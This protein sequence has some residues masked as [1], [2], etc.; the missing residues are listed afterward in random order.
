MTSFTALGLA[1]PIARAVA[2]ER[3]TDPTPIQAAAIPVILSGRDMIGIAQT[4]TGKTAAFAL[5]LLQQVGVTRRVAAAPKRCRVLVLTPTRELAG[6]IVDSFRTYGRHLRVSVTIAIGGVPIGKQI[7]AVQAGIDVLV[8]TPG[9][10]LDL[11]HSRSLSLDAVE[12][13]VL[14]EA[15]RMLDMGFVHEVRRIAA[16]VPKQRQT[17]LF[18]AT[19]P[20]V[21]ARLAS[22]MLTN[23]AT[24]SVAPPS[25][26]VERVQQRAVHVARGDKPALLARLLTT[27]TIDRALIFSRTKHGA[28]RVV[29]DLAK[30]GIDSEAIHGNKSQGQR[31]RTLAA[32]RSGKVRMLVATDIAARGIDV[33]GVS[34]VINYDLPNVPESYVH[35]IGRTA[36]AGNT[37]IAIS[38]CSSDEA[39]FLRAIEKLIR[40]AIPAEFEGNYRPAAAPGPRHRDE[41]AAH[42]REERAPRRQSRPQRRRP[43]QKGSGIGAVDFMRRPSRAA[44]EQTR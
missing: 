20:P 19:M 2:D 21:I 18:S 4:G 43:T 39:P 36:R 14:D 40:Q 38:F 8:A 44:A 30:A 3:Y 10:L 34:H 29:R 5:P 13:L 22:E 12:L 23:P 33:D 16:M 11:I 41:R 31:E 27:E 28:D 1:E 35:R 6:Q 26:T 25:S 7:R 24:V 37:G 32:F 9:R 15:D 42:T 17:Q